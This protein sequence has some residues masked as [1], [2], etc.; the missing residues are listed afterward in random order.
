MRAVN[1][2]SARPALNEPTDR[3]C[4]SAPSVMTLSLIGA[5]SLCNHTSGLF[6]QSVR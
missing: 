5:F 2:L 4:L 3:A 1:H 6:D